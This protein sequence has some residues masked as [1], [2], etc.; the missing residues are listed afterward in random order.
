M[1]T[2]IHREP[3][4]HDHAILSNLPPGRPAIVQATVTRGAHFSPAE[5]HEI[6][7][8]WNLARSSLVS[9]SLEMGGGPPEHA[10]WD[11]GNKLDS[12]RNGP[13][14]ADRDSVS[15]RRARA[16]VRTQVSTVFRI[17]E[18]AYS[19]CRLF[20]ISS[21]ESQDRRKRA[22][23]PWRWYN[24]NRGS[25][26][27]RPRLGTR[28]KDRATLAKTGRAILSRQVPNDGFRTGRRMRALN[29]F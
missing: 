24:T 5:F 28:R 20:G 9:R 10:D 6:Q 29:L 13:E 14:Y 1:S 4:C 12:N 23:V 7:S 25:Y 18:A 21:L 15:E 27:T 2:P 17:L 11:W 3:I 22:S 26:C 19:L 16:H 8:K